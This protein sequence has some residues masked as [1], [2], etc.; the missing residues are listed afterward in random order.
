[1]GHLKSVRH[2]L[3]IQAGGAWSKLS[4]LVLDIDFGQKL[5]ELWD[6]DGGK[7]ELPKI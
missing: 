7:L 5:P 1:L 6:W 3:L 2:F 4:K